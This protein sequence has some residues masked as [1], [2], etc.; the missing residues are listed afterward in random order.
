M[1]F[2][3]G[4]EDRRG[5]PNIFSDRE[6]QVLECLVKDD[7]DYPLHKIKT[8]LQKRVISASISTIQRE[9]INLGYSYKLK[10]NE[11]GLSEE[12][13]ITRVKWCEENMGRDWSQVIWSDESGISSELFP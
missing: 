5:R 2:T 12:D 13:R 4:Q 10:K 7:N 6:Q 1:V 8:E 3:Q 11:I 9:I